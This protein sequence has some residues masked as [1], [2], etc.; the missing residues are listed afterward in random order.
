MDLMTG[1]TFKHKKI[2]YVKKDSGGLL[3]AEIK[4]KKDL[5]LAI[6]HFSKFGNFK[7]LFKGFLFLFVAII[8]YSLLLNSGSYLQLQIAFLFLGLSLL[9]IGINFSHDA[10]HNCLTGNKKLD[11]LILDISFGLQGI[12]PY[13]WKIRHNHSHHPF[14]NIY[15]YDSDL[16]I[17]KLLYQNPYQKKHWL[18]R[19]QHLYAPLLY[20]LS[21]IIWIFYTDFKFFLKKE[22][23]N[24]SSINHSKLE[25]WKLVF[26]KLFYLTYLI[27]F[28]VLF[29]KLQLLTVLISFVIMH[30]LLSLF[31]T[32]TF[33][34]SH[35]V[36]ETQYYE[37]ENNK[38]NISWVEQQIASTL[39]F[40]AE[41]K[42]AN[43]FFGGFNAH[44]AHHLFPEVCHIHYPVLTKLI[45]ESL[46]NH[47][48]KYKSL[49]FGRAISSHF[50]L[51]KDFPERSKI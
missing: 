11:S 32:L 23:A 41:S 33:F 19:Y 27:V 26:A 21:S 6:N 51:L 31:L 14:P 34:I 18:H 37:V 35:H 3:Y 4:R 17:T 38:L 5:Y 28:P 44:V 30:L 25:W 39:D 15:G 29:G 43:F 7:L 1:N 10:A 50:S 12:N 47:K 24:L 36:M 49:S 46:N 22:H 13:L 42:V 48:V 20:M 2:K 8:A 45:K 16:D 40:H 9:L